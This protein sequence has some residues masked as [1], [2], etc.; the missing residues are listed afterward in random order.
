MKL[1]NE[2][3]ISTKLLNETVMSYSKDGM[4]YQG[5]CIIC[6]VSPN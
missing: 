2:L 6:F 4:P 5:K 3:N 1:L